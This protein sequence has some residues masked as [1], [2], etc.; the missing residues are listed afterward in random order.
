MIDKETW[1]IGAERDKMEKLIK[2]HI[3]VPYY[4][5]HYFEKEKTFSSNNNPLFFSMN[6]SF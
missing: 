6:D 1:K 5:K 3:H 4:K 2:Y